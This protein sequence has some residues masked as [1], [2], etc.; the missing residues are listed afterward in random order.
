MKNRTHI[1]AFLAV[2]SLLVACKRTDP[3][4]LHGE[5]AIVFSPSLTAT[6]ALMNSDGLDH[7]G[8]MLR[9]YDYLTGYEGQ[10]DGVTHAATD[11]VQYFSD[12]IIYDSGAAWRWRYN[13]G[14]EYP[15]TRKGRHS[16]FG[17]LIYDAGSTQQQGG[18]IGATEVFGGWSPVLGAN[19]ILSLPA[20]TFTTETPQFDFSYSNVVTRDVESSSFNPAE[21]V[22]IHLSHLFSAISMTFQNA[23]DIPVTIN[24]ITIPAFPNLGSATVNYRDG[25]VSYADP[26]PGATPFFDA[27]KLARTTLQTGDM[28]N[29]FNGRQN[30]TTY[31]LT[32]P[33]PERIISPST[34]I[35]EIDEIPIYAGTDSLIHVDYTIA[36][37]VQSG[38]AKFPAIS[39]SPGK[40]HHINILFT[41]KVI[42][43]TSTVLDWDFNDLTLNFLSDAVTTQANVGRLN[44]DPT[45]CDFNGSAKTARMTTGTGIKCRMHVLTPLGA[46]LVISMIGDTDYFKVTPSVTTIDANEFVFYVGASDAP[47]GGVNRTVHL[48]FTVILPDGREVNADSEL[49]DDN[50]AFIRQ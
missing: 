7:N 19:R 21:K 27:Y 47:T 32:W 50:Y 23:A 5:N 45:S 20:V 44:V 17:W 36:G 4:P 14:N 46:T 16:F 18:T 35:D 40:K 1:L 48:S 22:D 43:V 12:E 42:N 33:A 15:W 29:I 38:K 2:I 10:I 31:Y 28:Y 39:L 34:Q 41:N 26:V 8:V 49:I 6:R 11:T 13:S 24:A 3:V 9:V 30:D 37:D 25:S